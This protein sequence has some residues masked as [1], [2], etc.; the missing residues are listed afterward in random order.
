MVAFAGEL[1]NRHLQSNPMSHSLEINQQT[2]YVLNNG[3]QIP[4]TGYGVY[5]VSQEETAELVFQALQ[6][7]YRHVD[8]AVVYGN[9]VEVAKGIARFLKETGS[10]REEIFFTTKLWNTQQGYE[11]TK[12]ALSEINADIAPYIKYVDLLLLH[13]PL[14][15]REKRLG[16]WKALEEAVLNPNEA[17]LKIQSI[18]VSNF[19]IE[20]LE[21]LLAQ[22]T[23]KPAVNQLELHPWLPRLELREYLGRHNILAEAYSPL[24]QGYKLNEPELLELEKESGVSKIEL[25][26]KWSFLQGFV[27]L[28]KSNKSERI[29]QNLAVLPK[30]TGSISLTEREWKALDKPASHD[31]VTW[32]NADPTVYKS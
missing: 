2:R 20:H 4:V 1:N 25:L 31:V 16:T 6:A 28:A 23:I 29:K 5:D 19:G 32:G 21:E 30:S 9:Q 10:S 26:L 8:T 24:T 7:G 12:R 17:S 13:S 18:G 3:K 15:S 22:A 14:T 11:E 27:V